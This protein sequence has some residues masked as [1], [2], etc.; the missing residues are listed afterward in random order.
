MWLH[1]KTQ[2]VAKFRDLNCD[3]TQTLCSG[4]TEH[5]ILT[6]LK[7]SRPE[8]TKFLTKS[9]LVRTTYHL[10]SGH[11]FI[12]CYVWF[13]FCFPYTITYIEQPLV[14][15]QPEH[16]RTNKLEEE[17]MSKLLSDLSLG[18]LCF[19]TAFISHP[20]ITS[21]VSCIIYSLLLNTLFCRWHIAKFKKH[22]S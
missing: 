14:F 18:M 10:Y 2:I 19:L 15:G 4:K 5:F 22:R 20:K 3:K 7:I 9:L 17:K 6:K 11:F 21:Q 1:S 13:I 8:K 16:I 12:S